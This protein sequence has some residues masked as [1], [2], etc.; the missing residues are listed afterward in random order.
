[1]FKKTKRF[2]AVVAAVI[3]PG[4]AALWSSILG[5][6]NLPSPYLPYFY[7]G[8][9][10]CL[11]GLAAYWTHLKPARDLEK[12]VL[13]FLTI[14]AE[15]P[16]K[17]GRKHNIS[18]RINLMLLCRPWYFVGRKRIKV[19]WGIGMQNSPDVRFSCKCDRGVAGE[20]IRTQRPVLADC[21]I[22]DKT[23]FGFT[24]AQLEQTSHVTAVW[25]WPIYETNTAGEQTGRVVGV[26]N[27]DATRT[28][29]M[30]KLKQYNDSFERDLRKLC[31]VISTV[32]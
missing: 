9:V 6:L 18:P 24:A 8:T 13:N 3:I 32:V 30:V 27:F 26:V 10:M 31:E 2:L 22:A 15:T 16:L 21:E 11:S 1:M 12:P 5:K 28:G 20:A 29:A 4:L 14:L 19:V 25:S 23:K 7:V 17:L